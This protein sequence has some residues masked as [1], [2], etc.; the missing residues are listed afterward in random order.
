MVHE[1]H[2]HR[3][4][5]SPRK[6]SFSTGL[7]RNSSASLISRVLG[8]FRQKNHEGKEK[9]KGKWKGKG[10][11]MP[12]KT[13][14]G[15]QRDWM[16]TFKGTHHPD[17]PR[18]DKRTQ[19]TVSDEEYAA[20]IRRMQERSQRYYGLSDHGRTPQSPVP[21]FSYSSMSPRSNRIS[22]TT[23]V[24]A[25]PHW[26]PN[27]DQQLP[28]D[29]AT[30]DFAVPPSAR[31]MQTYCTGSLDRGPI[32]RY[33]EESKRQASPLPGETFST[34][35]TNTTAATSQPSERRSSSRVSENS[36]TVADAVEISKLLNR[37]P[38]PPSTSHPSPGSEFAPGLI[39]NSSPTLPPRFPSIEDVNPIPLP[40]SY[41]H[42]HSQSHSPSSPSSL[43]PPRTCPWRGC[44]AV[45]TTDRE[46]QDNLCARCQDAL[47][48]RESAFFGPSSSSSSMRPPTTAIQ[49]THLETL[50]DLVGASANT[51]DEDDDDDYGE[52][53]SGGA[54]GRG[55]GRGS[56]G[57]GSS[58]G[59]RKQHARSDK[60]FS[61][62]SF[63]LLPAPRGKRRQIFEARQRA[64]GNQ[65]NNSA[66][67][68]GS[69][70]GRSSSSSSVKESGNE[71]EK[72]EFTW[73]H[74]SLSAHA[75]RH[76][77]HLP[78]PRPS[79]PQP[80]DF[81]PVP[82]FRQGTFGADPIPTTRTQPQHNDGDNKAR[83]KPAAEPTQRGS[84]EGGEQET[85]KP[86]S[87]SCSWT[88]DSRT[89]SL[90]NTSNS[91][92]D[93]DAGPASPYSAPDVRSK[94]R[95]KAQDL[96]PAPLIARIRSGDRHYDQYNRHQPRH[97]QD[98][99]HYQALDSP[100]R[101][102]SGSS[103]YRPSRDTL[104]YREI[105]DIID[106]YA[107]TH[108]ADTSPPAAEQK[109]KR[110]REREQGQGWLRSKA[111]DADITATFFADGDPEAVEMRR[112]GF[113]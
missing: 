49:D 48:P 18:V 67:A 32:V 46:K 84:E 40:R 65:G 38:K 31:A 51:E 36:R 30:T 77:N 72:N 56:N 108:K 60:R 21:N 97:Q 82:P 98:Y 111:D 47:C 25:E 63:K 3:S 92:E 76:H 14:E 105:E 58:S 78:H 44:H 79:N 94:T 2:R 17:R 53:N 85:D 99:Q 95:S 96:H 19:E 64:G 112:K 66:A 20:Q 43:S 23:S 29:T 80:E 11:K 75:E 69:N 5:G 22:P 27:D 37:E 113:I 15:G 101:S 73:P 91:S 103:S 6:I 8:S 62:G 39:L 68:S 86:A 50:R 109:Q 42:S 70:G 45:L 102:G 74:P 1:H 35:T 16:A 7:R 26:R 107:G 10:K 83:N 71:D 12:G 28:K 34:V 9:D 89:S 110:E 4:V 54:G 100:R 13:K 90:T 106:C 24:F 93:D 87:D 104:L 33:S 57:S 88:T 55:S 59:T 81:G 41:S 61:V 52:K